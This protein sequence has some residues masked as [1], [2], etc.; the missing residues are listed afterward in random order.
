MVVGIGDGL[1]D[2]VGRFLEQALGLEG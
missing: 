2:S 1:T